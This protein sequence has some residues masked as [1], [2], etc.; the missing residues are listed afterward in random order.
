MRKL[1][2]QNS[3]LVIFTLVFVILI[4]GCSSLKEAFR[5]FRGVS[6]KILEEGRAQAIVKTFNYDYFTV[7]TKSL[8]SLKIMKSYVYAQDVKKHMIA[9][10]VSEEDTTPVGIFFKETGA[11]STQV[12]VASPSTYAKEIISAKLFK[13][14]GTEPEASQKKKGEI[15]AKK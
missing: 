9:I 5:G 13:A 3:G 8:D 4:S 1:K 6:T 15:D 2:I 14:L 11:S 12:E 10:Y 7:F